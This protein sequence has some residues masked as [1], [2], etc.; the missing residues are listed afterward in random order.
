MYNCAKNKKATWPH[1][2]EAVSDD[3]RR[4]NNRGTIV[5]CKLSKIR[6]LKRYYFIFFTVSNALFAYEVLRDTQKIPFHD[7]FMKRKINYIDSSNSVTL[8]NNISFKIIFPFQK[9]IKIV[10]RVPCTFSSKYQINYLKGTSDL[11]MVLSFVKK[12]DP[13]IITQTLI[14]P[15]T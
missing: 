15:P 2:G 6:K 5:D 11:W 13:K 9:I 4:T 12:I 14:R 1:F 10:L 7:K 8:M 3:I